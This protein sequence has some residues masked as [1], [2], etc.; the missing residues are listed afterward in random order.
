MGSE[1]V[2]HDWV[3]ELNWTARI[4]RYGILLSSEFLFPGVDSKRSHLKVTS[5]RKFFPIFT[6][7]LL[8]SMSLLLKSVECLS[9]VINVFFRFITV[10]LK[11]HEIGCLLS[12][13]VPE[14]SYQSLLKKSAINKVYWIQ[15]WLLNVK[16]ALGKC[17][18]RS[19]L[20]V[21]L[22]KELVFVTFFSFL[23]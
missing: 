16:M 21:F 2:R 14:T 18:Q 3:T 11:W 8:K 20:L 22:L 10:L 4:F 9:S 7:S 19:L 15:I 5:S 13:K 23:N 17:W 1:T 6:I 12:Y